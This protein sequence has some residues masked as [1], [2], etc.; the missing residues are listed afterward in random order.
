MPANDDIETSTLSTNNIYIPVSSAKTPLSWDNNDAT[1]LGLLYETCKY[2][3]Q[4]GPVPDP[5]QAP[6][7]RT[8]QRPTCC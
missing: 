6:R 5:A 7:G 1:I 3:K 2:H 4:Q 8:Q